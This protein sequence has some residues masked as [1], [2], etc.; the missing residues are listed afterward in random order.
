VT[1]AEDAERFAAQ[2]RA[3]KDRA[4][5]SY[6]ELAKRTKVS[7]SSLHRYCSGAKVP[8]SYG[9]V[10][11]IGKACG[12]DSDELR[13]LHRLWALADSPR[14]SSASSGNLAEHSKN[15][16]SPAS[17]QVSF[18]RNLHV[19]RPTIALSL[20]CSI[21]RMAVLLAMVNGLGL[22]AFHNQVGTVRS[23]S[24]RRRRR[25]S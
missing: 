4:G 3:L 14:S 9:A 20:T 6:E 19:G 18:R 1:Q 21:A 22:P 8:A 11:A 5:V 2:I 25:R 13:T 7:S 17:P 24:G 15:T 12:A 10:H 16:E 23:R